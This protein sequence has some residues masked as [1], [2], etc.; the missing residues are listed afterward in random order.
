[1]KSV[2]F[3]E[4]ADSFDPW[5]L[6]GLLGSG[7]FSEEEVETVATVNSFSRLRLK[8]IPVQKEKNF[9]IFED[10]KLGEGGFGVVCKGKISKK[11][12]SD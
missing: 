10:Q 4:S 5:K 2:F 11:I 9:Q 6:S 1:M 3:Q 7:N 12:T 8:P